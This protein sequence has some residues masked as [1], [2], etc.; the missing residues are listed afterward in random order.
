MKTYFETPVIEVQKFS[1]N[2]EVLAGSNLLED[3]EFED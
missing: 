3:D 1:A 2:E